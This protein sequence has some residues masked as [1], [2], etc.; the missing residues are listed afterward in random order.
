MVK[1]VR[2]TSEERMLEIRSAALVL[3]LEKGYS[4][5]T[6]DDIVNSVNL[7]KGSVYRYY[8]SKYI[9]LT[10]LLKD[11]INLRN[12]IIEEYLSKRDISIEV[13][14]ETLAELFFNE[15]SSGDYAKLYVIF[16]YEKMFD[17]NLE[18]VYN[19][20]KLYGLKTMKHIEMVDMDKINK[21]TTM[22]NTLILGKF[23]LK[24]EFDFFVDKDLITNM[25]NSVL[26]D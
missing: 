14:S 16:L 13:C 25:F 2:K 10:D 20:V 24:G 4:A 19:S 12:I 15:A 5:T 26:E 9:I 21:I 18:D 17:S 1:F 3:F 11:G 6:M 7:S 22:M 23:I 8:P